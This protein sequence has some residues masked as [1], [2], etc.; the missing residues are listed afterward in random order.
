MKSKKKWKDL[1]GFLFIL[2]LIFLLIFIPV[3]IKDSTR[4]KCQKCGKV[5]I[6]EVIRNNGKLYHEHCTYEKF[7]RP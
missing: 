6:D 5:I 1:V 7:S 4:P 2:I 3:Y